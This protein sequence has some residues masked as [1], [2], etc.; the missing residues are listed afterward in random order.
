MEWGGGRVN[1][2]QEGI[3]GSGAAYILS[4]FTGS[5][6]PDPL[7]FIPAKQLIQI[8]RSRRAGKAYPQTQGNKYALSGGDPQG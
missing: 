6:G 5:T 3:G 1:Q 7:E 2:C 8:Y 4:F